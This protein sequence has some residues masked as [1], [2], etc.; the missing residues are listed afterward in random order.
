V[1]EGAGVPPFG[2][3]DSVLVVVDVDSVLVVVV[4]ELVELDSSESPPQP[5]NNRTTP[6][7]IPAALCP[8]TRRRVNDRIRGPG[9][10]SADGGR[11]LW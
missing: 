10:N 9:A 7:S 5:A 8:V 6:T 3:V 4:D 1:P 11:V 2:V